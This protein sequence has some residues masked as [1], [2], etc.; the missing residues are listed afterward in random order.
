MS[1]RDLSKEEVLRNGFW[2]EILGDD[3]TARQVVAALSAIMT[4]NSRK[5]SGAMTHTEQKLCDV[6]AVLNMTDETG[7][8]KEN[9]EAKIRRMRLLC[10]KLKDLRDALPDEEARV[11]VSKDGKA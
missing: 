1:N 6:Q 8:L 9:V 7:A 10:S 3:E 4:I 11:K 5:L 2:M